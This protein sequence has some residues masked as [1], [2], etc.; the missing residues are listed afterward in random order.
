MPPWEALPTTITTTTTMNHN[1]SNMLCASF[2]TWRSYHGFQWSP[3]SLKISLIDLKNIFRHRLLLSCM[4]M[5]LT[6][7]Y[8]CVRFCSLISK[9][10]ARKILGFSGSTE[11]TED[12]PVPMLDAMCSKSKALTV[13]CR[14]ERWSYR[15]SLCALDQV[16]GVLLQKYAPSQFSCGK[17]VL[18]TLPLLM[19]SLL[20]T[21]Q[22]FGDVPTHW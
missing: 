10:L 6:D 3:K 4:Y 21:V 8:M 14:Q 18:V 15:N 19:W 22:I 1:D 5:R 9:P 20:W 11:R 7:F 16:P 2:S 17:F 13:S 12:T